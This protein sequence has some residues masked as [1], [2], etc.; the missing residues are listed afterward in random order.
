MVSDSTA[1]EGELTLGHVLAAARLALSDVIVLRHTYTDDGLRNR[2]GLTAARVLDY[3]RWQ[4][5]GNKI[6]PNPPKLW[7]VAFHPALGQLRERGGRP[8][9]LLVLAVGRYPAP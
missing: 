9:T 1:L 4:G 3:T 7:L 8:S 6:G 2:D 5:I